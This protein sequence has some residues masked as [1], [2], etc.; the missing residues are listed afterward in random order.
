MESEGKAGE[1]HSLVGECQKTMCN[2]WKVK[3]GRRKGI[4]WPWYEVSYQ[5]LKF[6]IHLKNEYEGEKKKRISQA[7]KKP[8]INKANVGQ[9]RKEK[10]HI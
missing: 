6:L 1:R 7:P 9:N 4:S 3:E 10:V 8:R 2:L 5:I